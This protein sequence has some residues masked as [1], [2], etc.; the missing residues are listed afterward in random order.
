[1]KPKKKIAEWIDID[2]EQQ[3]VDGTVTSALGNYVDEFDVDAIVR[4]YRDAIGEALPAGVVLVGSEFH[5][6]ADEGAGTRDEFDVW[7][8][9]RSV[10]LKAIIEKYGN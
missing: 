8:G 3:T 10:D 7:R 9:V 6:P 2:R 5:A 4:E 1:M